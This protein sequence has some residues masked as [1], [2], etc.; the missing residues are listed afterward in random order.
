MEQNN[1]QQNPEV[2]Q[3][4]QFNIKEYLYSCLGRWYWFVGFVFICLALASYYILTTQKTYTRSAQVMIKNDTKGRS[5]ST[6]I[7]SE[8]SN[9]GIF[10]TSSKVSNELIAFQSFDFMNEVV[11]NLKLYMNYTT[12]GFMRPTI[13]Y[14][15]NLP[16]EVEMLDVSNKEGA[17]FIVTRNEQQISA[18]TFIY[19]GDPVGEKGVSVSGAMGDTLLTPI[20]RVV[21]KPSRYSSDDWTPITVSKAPVGMVATSYS[22]RLN[23]SLADK[24]ADVIQLSL[25]DN[26][27]KRAE[28][29]LNTLIEVYNEHWV[30][31][32]NQIAKSTSKFID[33]RLVIIERELATV[34]T[35][36]STYK[37][38]NLL[39]DVNAAANLYMQQSSTIDSQLLDLSNQ[40]HM[41]KYIK[42]YILDEQNQTNLLPA[43]SGVG[44]AQIEK[45]IAEYNERLIKRNEL[46][47]NSSARNALVVD[48]DRT[49]ST[50]RQAI[51]TSVDNQIFALN[52]QIENLQKTGK[53]NKEQIAANPT[54][55]KRLLSVE[56]QQAVKQSLYLFLL[57]K[58]EENELSQAFTAYNTRIIERPRGSSA[59]T[60]PSKS[61][62]FLIAFVL[63]L[64][65]PAGIIYLQVT[66]DTR[67][68]SKKDIEKYGLPI[69]G[70]IP[71][72]VDTEKAFG[73]L[74]KRSPIT[75]PRLVKP[76]KRDGA[77][78]AFR[79]LRTNIEFMAAGTDSKVLL[80]TSFNPGSGK[81]FLIENISLSLAI[82]GKKVCIIDA[83]IRKGSLSSYYNRPSTGLSDYLNGSVT[84]IEKISVTDPEFKTLTII[85]SGTIPPNP[86]E[87]LGSGRFK[88]LIEDIREKFDYILI[89]SAPINIV[90]D[91]NIITEFIDRVFFIVRA[92]RFDKSMM[93]ELIELVN[94]GKL[95]NLSIILNGV[96]PGG[97]RYG[98]HRYGYSHYGY[99]RYGY[100]SYG[101]GSTSYGAYGSYEDGSDKA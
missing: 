19:N 8:F 15:T 6:D 43:N 5:A 101:Y 55:A 18:S 2:Q 94:A 70:E 32:K 16:I 7:S 11:L 31:D 75:N 77:N 10:A 79:V 24:L 100:H 91:T 96:E 66:L 51:V 89:D 38:E 4:E 25:A 71:L 41:T 54:Q 67:V 85:P 40:L 23:A 28:D 44:S 46:A 64:F 3:E 93:P 22:K 21:V 98:Y 12:D 63:G 30:L 52:T 69:A 26:V 61:K 92:G 47:S 13:L 90:A 29:V 20:G 73:F 95:K 78:E 34:D 81:T 68:H 36:I 42:S 37:S 27:A 80:V 65:I 45:Q 87:L 60:A 74:E 1:I 84:D 53:K 56:R 59:P 62:V 86:A 72:C 99:H 83:D 50:M 17:S 97:G 39:P 88:T 57:Q 9:L 76:G 35:D 82:K 14:G 49:L 58:R 48:L 33:N